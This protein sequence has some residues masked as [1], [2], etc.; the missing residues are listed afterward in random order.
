[1]FATL[2]ANLTEIDWGRVARRDGVGA[3]WPTARATVRQSLREW[4]RERD[5]EAIADALH[6]LSD[7]QLKLIGMQRATIDR[8][9]LELSEWVEDHADM[10]ATYGGIW[11][12]RNRPPKLLTHFR[13]QAVEKG[14]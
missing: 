10:A 3:L 5:L 14:A 11:A 7:R 13:D 4:R 12:E 2:Y 1:M 9:V 8:D 6:E